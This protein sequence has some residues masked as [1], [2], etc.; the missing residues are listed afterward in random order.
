MKKITLSILLSIFLCFA[1]SAQ[2]DFFTMNLGLSSGI[3]FYGSQTVSQTA[4]EIDTDKRVIIGTFVNA[5]FNIIEQ[6]TFFFGA[7]LLTDLN[8]K[9]SSYKH[10]L[11]TG[12][13]VGLKIYPG[14]GG[15]DFG[16]AYE[17]GFR[18]DFL[19]NSD[20]DRNNTSM[21]WG[22]GFKL[23]FEYNFAH[24]SDIKH[25]PII[26]CSWTFMPRGNY[27]YDNLITFYIAGNL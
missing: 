19:K 17:F 14:L 2:E 21:A 5:N 27:S 25:L 15:L 23:F 16:L 20:G 18:A 10:F 9:D 12:F 3:P 8:W 4:S 22:N 11:H 6:V 13:P 1:A 26:G 24:T 7:D